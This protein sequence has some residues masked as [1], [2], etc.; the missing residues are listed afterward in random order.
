ML[1]ATVAL[2]LLGN[3]LFRKKKKYRAVTCRVGTNEEPIMKQPVPFALRAF[4]SIVLTTF[5]L[6]A[7][8]ITIFKDGFESP[9]NTFTTVDTDLGGG[10]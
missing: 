5:S 8:G 7:W 1:Y 6:Q 2:D 9:P 3:E 4:L 10:G